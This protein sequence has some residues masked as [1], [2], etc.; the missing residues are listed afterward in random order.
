MLIIG[1]P[2]L[3]PPFLRRFATSTLLF[4]FLIYS[5]TTRFYLIKWLQGSENSGREANVIYPAEGDHRKALLF[6]LRFSPLSLLLSLNGDCE[7]LRR[8]IPPGIASG[9]LSRSADNNAKFKNDNQAYPS[10]IKK[11]QRRFLS[12]NS[13]F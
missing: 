12:E 9:I 8:R 7:K 13:F 10:N 1:F 3:Y 4:S 2:S 11:R 6:E 5:G